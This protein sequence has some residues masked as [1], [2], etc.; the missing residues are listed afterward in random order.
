VPSFRT[1]VARQG[2]CAMASKKQVF[3]Q[4]R[5]SLSLTS[6]KTI[7]VSPQDI[8]SNQLQNTHRLISALTSWCTLGMFVGL[9]I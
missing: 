9:P 7:W 2:M 4:P 3:N 8:H 1:H 6:F 5:W